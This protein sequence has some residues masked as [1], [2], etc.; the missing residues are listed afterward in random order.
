MEFLKEKNDFLIDF[1][2][3]Y[4]IIKIYLFSIESF[5]KLMQNLIK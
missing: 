5:A 3:L 2:H 1:I 4:I